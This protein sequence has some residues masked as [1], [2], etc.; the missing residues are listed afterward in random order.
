MLAPSGALL[1]GPPGTGKTMFAHH[2]CWQANI[3]SVSLKASEIYSKW[4]G[5]SEKII[6]TTFAQ[7]KLAVPSTI[8]MDEIDCIFPSRSSSAGE[9]NPSFLT[10]LLIEMD[11][12]RGHRVALVATTDLLD[13][14][15]LRRLP[16]KI[17]VPLPSP[18][19]R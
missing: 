13:P 3:K 9:K 8:V 2:A 19:A 14:A 10:Q 15:L 4:T 12:V 17:E 16:V 11:N 6:S 1:H 7:A 18:S 5:I